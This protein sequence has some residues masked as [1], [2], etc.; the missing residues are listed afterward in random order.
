M[1]NDQI[2]A[3]SNNSDA[4]NGMPALAERELNR[5]LER[6]GTTEGVQ[7]TEAALIDPQI[8]NL[9]LS[10]AALIAANPRGTVLDV[11]CGDGIILKRLSEIGVFASN[12]SWLYAAADYD[13][14][15]DEVLKLAATLRLHRRVEVR[16]LDQLYEGWISPESAPTPRVV[17]IR[18]V[19]H[20]L[21]I[22][23]TSQLIS[24]LVLHVEQCDT[25][26]LQDLEVFP[27]AER[28]NACWNPDLL[29]QLLKECG[30]DPISVVEP[31]RTGNRW[32]TI[33]AKRNASQ[34]LPSD[35]IRRLVLSTRRKQLELWKELD[36]IVRPDEEMRSTG[37]AIIDFDLQRL[38]LI[39]QLRGA[40]A[41]DVEAP[42][43]EE[44]A[45]A[46]IGT[47]AMHLGA[48]DPA[49]ANLGSLI[50]AL[51][52]PPHFRDRA[53]SQDALEEF[54]RG[55]NGVAVIHGGAY[56][57]KTVLVTEVLARRARNRQPIMVDIQRTSTAWN[58]V[59]QLLA[60]VGCSFSYALLHGFRV[61]RFDDVKELFRGLIDRS[62]K[63]VVVV[64]DH[65]ERL[66][67]PNA[68]VSDP[69]VRDLLRML[70]CSAEAK[71]ILT[72]RVTP[73]LSFLPESQT[74]G[75]AQPPVYRFPEEKHVENVLDDFIDRAALGITQ[76]PKALVD[77]ID[78]HPYLT[79]LAARIIT[80]EGEKCLQD[81]D[82]L[83]ML[84]RK[85][86]AELLRRVVDNEAKPAV[87]LLSLIRIPVPRGVFESLSSKEATAHAEELGLLY[88]VFDR[89][90]PDLLAGIGVFRGGKD[91]RGEAQ[92]STEG[93]EDAA[94]VAALN[95]KHTA[96]AACYARLFRASDDPRWLREL[97]YH[98]LAAGDASI[99][100]RF[101]AMYRS[102]LYWAGNVW[103]HDRKDFQAALEAFEAARN[104]GLDRYEVDMHI[105]ACHLRIGRHEE[106]V[107]EYKRLITVYPGSNGIKTSYI[108][109]LL[110]VGMY[111]DALAKLKEFG[112]QPDE[113]PWF[114]HEYGRAYMGL[115]RYPDGVTAFFKQ[116]QQRPEPIAYFMLAHACHRAGDR[117]R[118]GQ[119][120]ELG[121]KKY[122]SDRR[123]IVAFASHLI[124]LRTTEAMAAAER[125]LSS[126]VDEQPTD[127][128]ALQQLVKV[129]C[130]RGRVED[131]R[132]ISRIAGENALPE[133]FRLP[134]RV[135]VMIASGLFEAAVAD[136]G[137][138]PPNNMHLVGL[139][140]KALLHWA[141][142]EQSPERRRSISRHGLAVPVDESLLYNIPVLVTSARLAELAGD[143]PRY[144]DFVRRLT[145]LNPQL[146]GLFLRGEQSVDYWEDDSFE[147]W[148]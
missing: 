42:S 2:G 113:D 3:S 40:G 55:S 28:G 63:H 16:T 13:E 9:S 77:A 11:G 92:H 70:V 49:R 125:M 54:L 64:F 146:G 48:F 15:L 27:R 32:F 139:K 76:Y 123:L 56:M 31:S 39:E 135:E 84:R 65:F 116:C 12:P 5:F 114:A 69:E 93:R 1:N 37:I 136:L 20:E 22:E 105:A 26:L 108:D 95:G 137:D 96:I 100:K 124:R 38:A 35:S 119:V 85:M 53:R 45:R 50:V 7:E 68:S 75:A 23:K 118:V 72:T 111:K 127:G 79:I 73:D 4:A 83:E 144:D 25:I 117:D 104:F 62:A 141:R 142:T 109:S 34:P 52:R 132:R 82:F 126:L 43:A 130:L 33:L 91:D 94:Y 148:T 133:H 147:R 101:G 17:V 138:V 58:L 46:A 71:V 80:K 30:F 87:E 131:A 78:K 67:D 36:G 98:S 121:L 44:Q 86:R 103:F 134:I 140:K 89:R 47:F 24:A 145:D 18:N 115:Y 10:L 66:L 29:D 41:I 74:F 57:G 21:D 99:V 6:Y 102:E 120:L 59:E 143:V 112:L 106:G 88:P 110:Y 60:G 19:L 14:H 129:L 51:D 61:T 128:A 122:R 97:Y 107:R 8:K 90:F 81:Q